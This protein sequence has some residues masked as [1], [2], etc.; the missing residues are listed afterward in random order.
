MNVHAKHP[1]EWHKAIHR[2]VG[3]GGNRVA[4]HGDG[5]QR[6]LEEDSMHG[7]KFNRGHGALPVVEGSRER[8]VVLLF[9]KLDEE[10][11][12]CG[13]ISFE[14]KFG[15]KRRTIH[16]RPYHQEAPTYPK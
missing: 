12:S 13:R 2:R 11:M 14:R 5:N 3:Q 8:Y 9:V 1:V 16:E 15:R 7:P 6:H 4:A 10:E